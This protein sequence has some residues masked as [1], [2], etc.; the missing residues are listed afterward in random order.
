MLAASLTVLTALAAVEPAADSPPFDATAAGRVAFA[1]VCLKAVAEGR[2][3]ADLAQAAGMEP[4]TPTTVGAT[5]N[6]K[7]WKVGVIQP[8]HVVAWT[9][10]GCT[11]SVDRGDPALLS[12]MARAIILARP[13][14]FRAGVSGLYD[15]ER[16]ER[17]IYCA[18]RNGRWTVASI[19]VPGPKADGR[20]R[21]LS[22]SAYVRPT[23][24]N[25]CRPG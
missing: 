16:V 24:S 19:T 21:A 4:V 14:G 20:T 25:L 7:A 5:P 2:P 22:S 9:D 1:E 17:S 18:E 12:A 23:P 13:E 11:A 15:G 3:V 8:A 6:D 10:G